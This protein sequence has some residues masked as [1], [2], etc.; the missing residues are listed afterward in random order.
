MEQKANWRDRLSHWSKRGAFLTSEQDVAEIVASLERRVG[1]LE[2]EVER[3]RA[4]IG[5]RRE[6]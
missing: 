3:L 4:E 2:R 6:H 1:S 5:L